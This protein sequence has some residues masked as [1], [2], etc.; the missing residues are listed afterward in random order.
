MRNGIR[1]Y[2]S[3][4]KSKLASFAVNVGLF[5]FRTGN[6]ILV[7]YRFYFVRYM[8]NEKLTK[9][10]RKVNHGLMKS[11]LTSNEIE[12]ELYGV[13]SRENGG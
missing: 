12:I 4:E 5:T 2:A 8:S 11:K 3:T 7:K 9:V 1:L 6:F 10:R 13:K